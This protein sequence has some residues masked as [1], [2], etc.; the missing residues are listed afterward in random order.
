MKPTAEAL[1]DLYWTQQLSSDAIAEQFGVSRTTVK[2]WLRDYKIKSRPNGRG[3]ANRGITPPTREELYRLVHEEYRSYREIAT[4]Y[5]VD[6]SAVQYWL[7]K[8]N[9][10]KPDLWQSR[11]GAPTPSLPE[12]DELRL[13]YSQGQSLAALAR[14]YGI[15][16]G[17]I[18]NLCNQ[19]DIT[20][21]PDGWDGGRRLI[22]ND[23]HHVRSTYE[24]RVDDWLASHCI[25]HVYEPSLPFDRRFHADFLANGWY[26]EIWGVIG[27]Q[28]YRARQERKRTMYK[29]HGLPLIEIPVHAFDSAHAGLWERRLAQ[30]LNQAATPLP[31]GMPV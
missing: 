18:E 2:R 25:A 1:H 29:V 23:G 20:R 5:G 31:L 7:T 11:R 30:C 15:A 12:P 17:T 8:H 4:I 16:Y 26:I 19:F 22:S 10:P 28:R 13:L 27:S 14:R 6:R 9:I 21:R 3:L 24:L